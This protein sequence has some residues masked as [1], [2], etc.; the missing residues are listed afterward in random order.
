MQH[1]RAFYGGMQELPHVVDF[2]AMGLYTLQ[3]VRVSGMRAH[4]NRMEP[5]LLGGPLIISLY[6]ALQSKERPPLIPCILIRVTD[7]ML[8]RT[9]R[10]LADSLR[11]ASQLIREHTNTLCEPWLPFALGCTY[12]MFSERFSIL[13][14]KLP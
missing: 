3:V 6:H 12:E 1:R 13:Q 5:H 7:R 14:R 10:I 9:V 4:T 8:F 11:E 2:Y